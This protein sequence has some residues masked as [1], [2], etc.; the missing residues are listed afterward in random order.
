MN[1]FDIPWKRARREKF[2]REGLLTVAGSD[3]DGG[4]RFTQRP[5]NVVPFPAPLVPVTVPE[6]EEVSLPW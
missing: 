4:D 5:E 6:E 1:D 2:A 3:Q